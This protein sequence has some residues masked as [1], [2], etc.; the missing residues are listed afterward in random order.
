MKGAY[1]A[2]LYIRNSKTDGCWD[3]TPRT[4]RPRTP[5]MLPTRGTIPLHHDPD[6]AATRRAAKEEHMAIM[7]KAT[8][9]AR[10]TSNEN[11]EKKLVGGLPRTVRPPR[12][13]RD[14]HVIIDET[15]C[16]P[17]HTA[18]HSRIR[19]ASASARIPGVQPSVSESALWKSHIS[20]D[21][22]H[23][24]ERRTEKAK[25]PFTY[26]TKKQ[27]LVTT[28][29]QRADTESSAFTFDFPQKTC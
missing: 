4:T 16:Y 7:L 21:F 5:T 10:R 2:T 29:D 6:P 17:L 24:E 19:P 1:D 18:P 26:F 14:H 3:P 12:P 15:C 25:S 20:R 13:H 11:V 28:P 9:T 22:R 27:V 23:P 8:T